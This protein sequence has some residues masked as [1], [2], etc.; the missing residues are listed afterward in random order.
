MIQVYDIN[1]NNKKYTIT[2]FAKNKKHKKQHQIRAKN[3]FCITDPYLHV[4]DI[5][6]ACLD[7]PK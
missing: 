6:L 4:D 5:A 1:N 2:F 7:V 3:N